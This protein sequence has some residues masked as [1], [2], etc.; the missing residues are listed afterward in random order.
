MTAPITY[1]PLWTIP[2]RVQVNRQG[3]IIGYA[4][5]S[6]VA[7]QPLNLAQ[8]QSPAV[9][10]QSSSAMTPPVTQY[11]GYPLQDILQQT[12]D[13]QNVLIG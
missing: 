3:Q 5:G 8:V 4:L 13:S 2:N 7:A 11:A 12:T 1:S 9:V 10:V 6:T